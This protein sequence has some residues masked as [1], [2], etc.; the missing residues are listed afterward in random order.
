MAE[1]NAELITG[2]NDEIERLRAIVLDQYE[3]ISDLKE[4]VSELEIRVS[5]NKI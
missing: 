5:R 2:L 4:Y 3:T 1:P